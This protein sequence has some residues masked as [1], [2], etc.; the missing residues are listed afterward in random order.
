MT[1]FILD[2]DHISLFQRGLS[3]RQE[4][5]T[6]V[7]SDQLAVTII[8]YEEQVR[9]WLA[10]IRRANNDQRLIQA[11]QRL[12]ET[13]TFYSRIQ[14]L[15]FEATAASYFQQFR[16][17]QLRIG[18]QDLRIAAIVMAHNGILITR[19]GRDFS[20][21]PGLPLQDWSIPRD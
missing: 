15:S 12:A 3:L 2:T 19:N 6:A 17:Q 11:Y 8:S 14:V 4:R 5:V 18:T 1:L 21:I 13:L 9:G 16:Q 20:Q 10:H 7:P